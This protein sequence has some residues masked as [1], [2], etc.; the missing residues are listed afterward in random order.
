MINEIPPEKLIDLLNDR[1]VDLGGRD[2]IVL[3]LTEHGDERALDVLYEIA[4]NPQCVDDIE[5]IEVCGE[6]IAR[7]MCRVGK[8]QIRYIEGLLPYKWG[9]ALHGAI[10]IIK[11]S[12]PDWYNEYNLEDLDQTKILTRIEFKKSE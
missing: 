8:F 10:S 4:S 5:L 7:I 1:S 9:S 2:D 6:A 12:R 11:E 3:F